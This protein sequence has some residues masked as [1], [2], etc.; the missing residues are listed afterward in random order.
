MLIRNIRFYIMA[1]AAVFAISACGKAETE[2]SANK[3][4]DPGAQ[5]SASSETPPTATA[6]ASAANVAPAAAPV[7]NT[8]LVVKIGWSYYTSWS[9]FAAAEDFNLINGEKGKLGTLEKKYNVDIVLHRED[10]VPSLTSYSVGTTD[11]VFVTNTDILGFAETRKNKVGDASVATSETSYSWGADQVIVTNDIKDWAGLKGVTIMGAEFSV[12]HFMTW[13]ACQINNVNVADY[14]FVNLDPGVGAPQFA[15]KQAGL[16]AFVGWS[17]ET[18]TVLDARKTDMHSLFNSS[19]LPRYQI[20]DMFVIGQSVL[21]RGGDRAAK[22]VAEVLTEMNKKVADP[23]QQDAVYKAFSKR[24]SDRERPDM[25]RA[26]QLT[27]VA[28]PT[29]DNSILNKPEFKA[30]M[31]K[32]AEFVAFYKQS[33]KDVPYAWGTKTESPTSTLRFDTSYLP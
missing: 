24:F 20:T 25:E 30:I 18:F 5:A 9:W 19:M 16:K 29:R 10:Y 23:A 7:D 8:P 13:F 33:E 27:P 2:P 11:A 6:P 21:D 32:I 3:V 26:L 31:P 22:L 28:S 17:P 1:L 12:S 15:G 14:K 4:D